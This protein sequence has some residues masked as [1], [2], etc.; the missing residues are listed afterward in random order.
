[1]Y[2]FI[3]DHETPGQFSIQTKPD[4]CIEKPLMDELP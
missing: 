2:H 3:M 4:E 1:M